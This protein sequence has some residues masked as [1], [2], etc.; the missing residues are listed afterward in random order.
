MRAEGLH[1]QGRAPSAI[2][3]VGLHIF[4]RVDKNKIL[5][6][7]KMK[8]DPREQEC[9]PRVFT[10]KVG[11]HKH[12]R[13]FYLRP[14]AALTGFFMVERLEV[15]WGLRVASEVFLLNRK[16]NFRLHGKGNSNSHAQSRSIKIIWM[17]KLIRTRRLSIKNS[18]SPSAVRRQFSQTAGYRGI[19]LIRKRPPP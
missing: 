7:Q 9:A 5:A 12:R 15:F 8:T 11:P 19:S 17:I 14:G 10:S 16:V 18:L 1:K 4:D 6:I 2:L 13:F 3:L